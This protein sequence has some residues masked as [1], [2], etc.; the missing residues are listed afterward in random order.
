LP[1]LG[2]LAR[3]PDPLVRDVIRIDSIAVHSVRSLRWRCPWAGSDC[4]VPRKDLPHRH[5]AG[6][7]LI[8]P[9]RSA[10]DTS[11]DKG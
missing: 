2:S 4:P 3:L 6:Q 11:S 1:H 7:T 8:C 10:A 9:Q 5:R